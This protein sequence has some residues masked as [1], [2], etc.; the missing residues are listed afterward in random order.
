MWIV[1]SSVIPGSQRRSVEQDVIA[2]I[3][4]IEND[5]SDD[6]KFNIV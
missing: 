6:I 4:A 5:N 2:D 1:F 3:V